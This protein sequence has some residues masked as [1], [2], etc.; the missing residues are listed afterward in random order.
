MK[1]LIIILI[2]FVLFSTNAYSQMIQ[3]KQNKS[4]K[5]YSTNNF[6]LLDEGFSPSP[7]FSY[8]ITFGRVK[9]IGW[10]G[11]I[12]LGTNLR[13]SGDYE[14][15]NSSGFINN[16]LPFYSGEKSFSR[17]A[18]NT[19]GVIRFGEP[20]YLYGGI[21]YGYR[22]TFWELLNKEQVKNTWSSYSGFNFEIGL[23]FKIRNFIF[24]T[25]I[26]ALNTDYM[27]YK[28]GIGW[29]FKSKKTK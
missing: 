5:T 4:I 29:N 7:Q 15:D 1:K 20:V 11:S 10:Y 18:I 27:D 17:F 3:V 14:S 23:I 25:G 8:G 22:N 6:F 24:S 21:G 28:I 13:A 16:D 9:R 12:L 19:G 2:V 26:S